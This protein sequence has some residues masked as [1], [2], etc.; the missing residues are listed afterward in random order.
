MFA[1][2]SGAPVVIVNLEKT[3]YDSLAK[4]VV[5]EKLGDFARSALAAIGE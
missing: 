3:A 4:V 1:I 5:R 2:S